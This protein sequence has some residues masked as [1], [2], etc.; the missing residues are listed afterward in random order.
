MNKGL[1]KNGVPSFEEQ[2]E[3]WKLDY[4]GLSTHAAFFDYDKDGDIDCYLLNNSIRSVGGYDYRPGQRNIPDPNGGNRLLRNEVDHFEDVTLESGIYASA[5]GFGLGVTIGDYDGDGWQDIFV[6]NDF[7][8]RDYLYHN[9]GNGKFEEVLVSCIPEISKGSMGADMADLDNDGKPEIFV[10]E[11]TPETEKRYKTKTTFDDWNTYSMMQETGYHRQFGRN[12]LQ[13]NNGN[14]TFSEVGRQAGVWA[15]DW[16]WGALLADFDND[17]R[18]DIFVA[19]GI[20]K[21]LLDQDYLNFYSDPAVVRQLL[22]ENPGA[23]IKKLI[24]RIPSV[25]VPN[26]LFQNQGDLKFSNVADDWG[27]ATPSWSNGS[28][29]ADLD[30]DGDLDLLVNNVN[31]PCFVYRNETNQSQN[32]I[33]VALQ[34]VPPNTQ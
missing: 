1:D 17:G 9:L 18:K 16:S 2:S 20:G 29:Y 25:P 7:F 13:K 31:M 34:G 10:T 11:M 26:Y 23:G 19:N 24:D 21:D 15:T 28:A 22:K 27:L 12:V 33:T 30:N 14:Q 4:E 32:W 3:Q 6:S 5:I 8:E